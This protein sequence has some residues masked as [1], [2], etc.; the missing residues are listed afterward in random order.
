MICTVTFNPAVDYVMHTGDIRYGA[1]NRSHSEEIYFGGKGINVSSVL[2]ELGVHSKAF[3]F[4]GGFTGSAL[5]EDVKKRGI[6]AEFINA[7]GN[8]R[9]NVKLKG[10][11][12]TEI[13]ASGC[14]IGKSEIDLLIKR[15]KH[16]TEGD[17]LVL[18]GSVPSGVPHDTYAQ[19]MSSIDERVRCVVDASGELFLSSL[20]H[21]P[22]L[23]KPNRDE[24]SEAVGFEIVT[25]DDVLRAAT[26]LKSRGAANVLVSLGSDGA[27]L[28]SDENQICRCGAPRGSVINSCGAGD[29]MLA[30]YLAG[31][32]LCAGDKEKALKLAVAAGSATAFS[33]DLANRRFIREILSRM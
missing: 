15:L 32:S 21:M 14:M 8:T 7:P 4:V 17:T 23:I 33:S 28:L 2:L 11:S 9:I 12:E 27:L 10:T 18:A 6:D 22:Y 13:N 3:A 5:A 31:L 29:S 16:L 30:G 26:E 20:K 19:I 25:D 24:L 1:T